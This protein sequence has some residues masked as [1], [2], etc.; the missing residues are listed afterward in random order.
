MDFSWTTSPLNP[1]A[2]GRNHWD[3]MSG[4]MHRFNTGATAPGEISAEI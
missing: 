3:R 1:L 2:A 4:D